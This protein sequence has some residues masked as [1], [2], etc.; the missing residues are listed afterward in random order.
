ML[1]ELG[2]FKKLKV[3]FLLVVNTHNHSDQIFSYFGWKLRG[4]KVGIL[5]SL[6]EIVRKAYHPKLVV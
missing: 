1:V 4:N 5:P 6:I 2:I 3:G